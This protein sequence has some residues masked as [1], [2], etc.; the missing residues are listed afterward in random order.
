MILKPWACARAIS[1][2]YPAIMSSALG[3]GSPA[4]TGGEI[5]P[6]DVVDPHH[7]HDGIRARMAEDVAIEAGERV[8]AHAIAENTR[9][10]DPLVQHRDFGAGGDDPLG[11]DVRP[12]VVFVG[13]RSYRHR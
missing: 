7:D 9:A 6:P 3:A 12:A 10:G 2:S 13:G 11:K 1:C 8:L 4:G 5:R